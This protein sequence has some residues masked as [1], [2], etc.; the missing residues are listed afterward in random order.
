VKTELSP[1]TGDG[2]LPATGG[3]VLATLGS[4]ER[5]EAGAAG[6]PAFITPWLT[7]FL[8]DVSALAVVMLLALAQAGEPERWLPSAGAQ[9]A[10][11][12]GLLLFAHIRTA[13]PSL[14]RR[15][16]D[17][18][19]DLTVACLLAAMAVF[20]SQAIVGLPVD[21]SREIL[22]AAALALTA[23]LASRVTLVQWKQRALRRSG[24]HPAVIA[25]AGELGVAIAGRLLRHPELGLRPVG[26]FDLHPKGD[27]YKELGLPLASHGRLADEVSRRGVQHVIVTFQRGPD[28]ELLDEVSRCTSAGAQVWMVPRLFEMTRDRVALERL[29]GV[30]LLCI[31]SATPGGW[32]LSAKYALD[33]VMALF[34]LV[35]V[36]P[37]LLVAGVALL[38]ALGRPVLLRQKRVG[39]DGRV[40]ELLKL[41]TLPEGDTVVSPGRA[42]VAAFV[43]RM[44]LDELPQLMNVL[45]GEMSLVGP[46]PEQPH[47]A[48]EFDRTVYRYSDR[49]RVKSG[50]TGWAQVNGLGRGPDRFSQLSLTERAEWDNY[51]IENWSPWLDVK[52]L[53]ATAV[54][55]VRY[56]Q[57]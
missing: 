35:L 30:P 28:R 2:F 40:Y 22:L 6:R 46:R 27:D 9:A 55:V 5:L 21:P 24:G 32:R 56:R 45:R 50:I 42:A 31:A 44:S 17:T 12:G 15:L 7:V 3:S 4:A 11:A 38:A 25:G 49:L 54:A 48:A 43:R 20:S 18:C 47:L 34:G 8:A 1:S 29:G 39:H 41:R 33:R 16:L 57:V 51:Y 13:S 53:I 19:R 36:S 23:V 14:R 26:F 10:V 52:I 37:V